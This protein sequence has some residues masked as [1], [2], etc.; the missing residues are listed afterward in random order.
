MICCRLPHRFVCL[1]CVPD[2]VQFMICNFIL[3]IITCTNSETPCS[4]LFPV[5]QR[6]VVDCGVVRQCRVQFDSEWGDVLRL[7]HEVVESRGERE[8]AVCRDVELVYHVAVKRK[9][10]TGSNGLGG[11]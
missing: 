5:W 9:I 1:Q 2:L 10:E 3:Q 8:E 4:S 7:V 11:L 6:E